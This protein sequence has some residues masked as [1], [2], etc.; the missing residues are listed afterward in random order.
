M[1]IGAG[2]GFA[3]A[4]V[5]A[6]CRSSGGALGIQFSSCRCLIGMARTIGAADFGC[7]C[8]GRGGALRMPGGP[9]G[10]SVPDGALLILIGNGGGGPGGS[11]SGDNTFCCGAEAFGRWHAS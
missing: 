8:F 11:V 6:I 7:K 10:L 3:S 4:S 2:G 9:A 5:S 1:G